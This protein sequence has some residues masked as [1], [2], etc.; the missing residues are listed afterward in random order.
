M[1][2]QV[3]DFALIIEDLVRTPTPV[4]PLPGMSPIYIPDLPENHGAYDLDTEFHNARFPQKSL[5]LEK[6]HQSSLA[7]GTF[8]RH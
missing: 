2:F 5:V 4:M 7:L 3:T 6:F 8:S 1:S